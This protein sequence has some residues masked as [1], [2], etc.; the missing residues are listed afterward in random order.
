M[1][2]TD[3]LREEHEVIR[4]VLASVRELVRRLEAGE[5]VEPDL[6]EKLLEFITGFA[7]G[8]HH[9][10]EEDNLFPL[11]EQRGL[12]RQGGPLAVMLMEHSSGRQLVSDMRAALK[13]M[14]SGD[15]A[16][17]SDLASAA[18]SYHDLLQ[19]HID[20]ENGVLF[21]MAD[22]VLSDDD[23][24]DLMERFQHLEQEEVGSGEHQRFLSLVE[25]IERR[26]APAV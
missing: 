10:K 20:K 12:P 13:E 25:E 24:R 14:K 4:R 16:A 22:R 11:L 17:A 1:Q 26:L 8:C 6:V 18:R 21:P 9:K 23:Q 7:D 15:V 19:D 5:D 2:A 3:V